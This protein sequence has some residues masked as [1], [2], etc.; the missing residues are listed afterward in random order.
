MAP[1]AEETLE[2]LVVVLDAVRLGRAGSRSEIRHHSGLS[3]AVV[4]QRISDLVARSLIREGG[5]GRS[6]GGRRPRQLAFEADAGDVLVADL[7]A[8]SIDVALTDLAG[9]IRAHVAEDADIAAGPTAV[10][11]RVDELFVRLLGA[12]D[13]PGGGLWGIGIGVPGPVE[14]RTGRPASPPIMPGWDGFPIRQ[15]FA[16]RFD[17]PTWVDNDVNVMA[18]GEWRSGVAQ[19]H[20]NVVFVKI[21]TGIGAGL[22][23]DGVLHRGD[24]GA[25]GDVGHIQIVDDRSVVCRC[26]NVGVSKPSLVARRWR[27]TVMRSPEMDGAG[28]WP[29]RT[30]RTGGS[31]RPTWGGRLGRGMRPASRSS[32]RPA[33]RSG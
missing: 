4:A 15:R 21:G 32:R 6:T 3:R 7:G 5:A 30:R 18:L 2:G 14:F 33:G 16:E 17:A 28:C 31:R 22:I 13:R 19:G 10:L 20:S 29:R 1:L 9:R 12:S 23:S 8:T 24:K 27:T 11:D 25:A 26:G